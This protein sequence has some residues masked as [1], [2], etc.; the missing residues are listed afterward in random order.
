MYAL[1]SED[2]SRLVCIVDC[3]D[4]DSFLDQC[5]LGGAGEEDDGMFACGEDS[6]YRKWRR[7]TADYRKAKEVRVKL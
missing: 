7:E 2:E 1:E 6:V 5:G 4:V 3:A